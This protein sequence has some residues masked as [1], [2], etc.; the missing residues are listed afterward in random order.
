MALEIE[1][2]KESSLPSPEGL[3]KTVWGYV[4]DDGQPSSVYYVRWNDTKLDEALFVVSA[5]GWKEGEDEAS[6]RCIAA[7]GRAAGEPLSFM[8]V[9]AAATSFG[10]QEGLGRMTS[11]HEVRGTPLADLV[12]HILDHVLLDDPR[13]E[14][15]RRRL[16]T[17]ARL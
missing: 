14:D 1:P 9:D 15:L 4:Y 8:L 5:G 12:F 13:V 3:L 10:A 6:R 17:S 2:S 11:A 7:L 16:E